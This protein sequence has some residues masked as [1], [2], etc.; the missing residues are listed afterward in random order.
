MMENFLKT[1]Y[2]HMLDEGNYNVLPIGD[3]EVI[4]KDVNRRK[5]ATGNEG[6]QFQIEVRKD[7]PEES[8][9]VNNSGRFGGRSFFTTVWNS[10]RNPDYR[11]TSLNAIAIACGAAD[12]HIFTDFDDF[13]KQIV[14]KPVQVHLTHD[15]STF[16][17]EDRVQETVAPWDW[18]PTNFVI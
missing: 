2:E 9:L 4:I 7:I 6:I 18:E 11:F 1:D 10:D 3:Y 15:V 13:K 16:Q 8:S 5:A 12:N 17:G 14:K